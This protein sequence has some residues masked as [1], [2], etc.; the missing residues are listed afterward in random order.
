MLTTRISPTGTLPSSTG[1]K[2]GAY[3]YDSYDRIRA[4]LYPELPARLP[5]VIGLTAYGA[6][7]GLT[8]GRWEYG[9]RITL[10]PEVFQGTT[11]EGA[12][13]RVTGGTRQVDDVLV[14]EMLH[15][16]LVLAGLDSKHDGAPW[17]DAVRRLSPAVL[18]CDLDARRGAG[19]KSVRVPNPAY[20]P[21]NG[22]PK[23]LVRKQGTGHAVTHGDVARWPQ[24]FRPSDYNWGLAIPCP[25][26]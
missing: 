21:G 19:R 11:T 4:A 7:L 22:Q 12:R 17:Y 18:G 16:S 26:Y 20:A 9:P 13:R 1:E 15:V 24:A 23:T 14:H 8:R 10:P 25:T 6:C 2:P 3:A 5:I